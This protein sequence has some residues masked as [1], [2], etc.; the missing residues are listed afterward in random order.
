MQKTFSFLLASLF[1]LG[2][3]AQVSAS[4]TIDGRT[5]FP[6]QNVAYITFDS[7]ILPLTFSTLYRGSD[8][9]WN[10][11]AT[12]IRSN[13]D[14]AITVFC[15]G[16]WTNYTVSGAGVQQIYNGSKPN[17]VYLDG[18]S[19]LEFDGW[20]YLDG[21]TTISGSSSA[22][23]LYFGYVEPAWLRTFSNMAYVGIIMISLVPLCLCGVFIV[24]VAK[25]EKFDESLVL[26]ILSS[27]VAVVVGSYIILSLLRLVA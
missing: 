7:G 8:G 5:Y 14:M 19:R 26:G 12:K 11:D 25:D 23:A 10:F 18:V 17:A 3:V 16:N 1:L 13:V 15:S 9:F 22:V 21:T 27:A 20:S 4:Y 24:V 2:M 6:S